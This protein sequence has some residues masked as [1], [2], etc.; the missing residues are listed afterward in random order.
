MRIIIASNT[1]SL[2]PF[3]W[4]LH[5]EGHDVT[6]LV[7]RDRFEK[8]WEGLLPKAVRR[9]GKGNPEAL[10]PLVDEA[11]TGAP[12][13][14]DSPR[15][16][17][18]FNEAPFLFTNPKVEGLQGFPSVLVGGW[19]T[20]ERFVLPHLLVVDWGLWPGGMG[21]LVP[22]GATL[23]QPLPQSLAPFLEDRVD[24]L[25]SVSHRG[26]VGVGLQ[27]N[28][29]T[30]ELVAAGMVA[31]WTYLQSHLFV[32]DLVGFGDL[33][34]G[35]GAGYTKRFVVGVPVTVPP[36]PIQCNVS[37][38]PVAV[39]GL[40]GEDHKSIFFH[41]MAMRDGVPYVAGTDGQVAVVRG[42]ANTLGLARQRALTVAGKMQLPHKQYRHDAGGS[43]EAVLAGLEAAGLL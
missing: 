16:A 10:Q 29:E 26:L 14:T 39:D 15:F 3:A 20:G 36:F 41:D 22:G 24:E 31:G 28:P 35:T 18:L 12:V 1:H 38:V 2:L 43:T 19:F 4:R 7:N 40:D 5:K 27:A 37:S 6:V 30:Q 32:S 25:K 9:R 23:V 34:A 11:I 13:L 33:L 17:E 8:A 21:P 42:S